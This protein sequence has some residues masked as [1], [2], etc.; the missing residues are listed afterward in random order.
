MKRGVKRSGRV[1]K[2]GVKRSGRGTKRGVKRSVKGVRDMKSTR[3]NILRIPG[4]NGV[5]ETK[6]GEDTTLIEHENHGVRNAIY[7]VT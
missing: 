6:R 1:M 7:S 3:R 2:R 4:R 5:V